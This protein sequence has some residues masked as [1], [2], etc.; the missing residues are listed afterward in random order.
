MDTIFKKTADFYDALYQAKDYK[1]ETDF[2]VKVMEKYAKDKVKTILSFGCGTIGHEVLLAK[3]GYSIVGIDQAE[4]MINIAKEKAKQENVE[5]DLRV[6]DIQSFKADKQFDAVIANFNIAGYMAENADMDGF[7][8]NAADSLKEGGLLLFDCWYGPAVLKDRPHDREKEFE[9]GG[10]K[11]IRKTTQTLD[12]E[13]STVTILFEVLENGQSIAQEQHVVRFWFLKELELF[14]EKN[15]F[16]LVKA[17]NF[18]DLDSE[19][20]ENGWYIFL[21]AMKK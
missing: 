10:K 7:L 12:I 18:L 1:A 14:L 20:S 21:A 13:K 2:L 16:A 9:K 6:S 4:G 8:K 15:G 3:Q 5:I 17:C 11:F 19:I